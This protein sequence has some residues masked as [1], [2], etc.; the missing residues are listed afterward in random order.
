VIVSAEGEH[1]LHAPVEQPLEQLGIV[2]RVLVPTTLRARPALA[3]RVP[4]DDW[5]PAD[6]ERAVQVHPLV[7]IGVLAEH[8]VGVQHEVRTWRIWI[9]EMRLAVSVEQLAHRLL[10]RRF[11]AHLRVNWQAWSH[12][13]TARLA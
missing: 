5:L 11:G 7:F 2:V 10:D 6:A 4:R 12:K 9:P 8:A 13:R 1:R 3:P